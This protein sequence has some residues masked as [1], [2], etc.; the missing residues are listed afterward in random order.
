VQAYKTAYLGCFKNRFGPADHILT[1]AALD[2]QS[3]QATVEF[4]TR[5]CFFNSEYESCL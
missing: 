4:C 2:L 1:G 5:W 3:L